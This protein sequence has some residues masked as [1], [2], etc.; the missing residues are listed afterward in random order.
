MEKAVLQSNISW[1]QAIKIL[2]CTGARMGN[3]PNL[4][5]KYSIWNILPKLK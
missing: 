1:Q 4:D 5:K 3:I 2:N